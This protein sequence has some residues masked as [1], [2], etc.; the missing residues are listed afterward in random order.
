MERCAIL[1]KLSRAVTTPLS[2]NSSRIKG[3]CCGVSFTDCVRSQP[4][5]A[6]GIAVE[7]F[8]GLREI[9]A[10][11]GGR[12]VPLRVKVFRKGWR[13]ALAVDCLINTTDVT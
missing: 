8:Y 7:L 5:R 1:S 6:P 4:T 9:S 2:K 3:R 10:C 13:A 12:Q 11:S